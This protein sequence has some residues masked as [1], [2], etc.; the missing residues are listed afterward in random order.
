MCILQSPPVFYLLIFGLRCC[1]Y[2]NGSTCP[3][4]TVVFQKDNGLWVIG[5]RTSGAASTP[6]LIS[7]GVR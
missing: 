7:R 5:V 1:L 6:P 3:A 4:T 2:W